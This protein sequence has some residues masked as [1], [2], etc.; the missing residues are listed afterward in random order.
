MSQL[1]IS[2]GAVYDPA[3]GV[4][5]DV[6]D[7][8]IA[9]GRIVASLPDGAPRLDARGMV[10]MPGGIDMHAHIASSSVNQGRRLLPEEHTVDAAPAPALVEG[11]ARSGTG[12]T[13]PSTFTTGYRYAGLG[14][15]TVFDAAVAAAGARDTHAQLDDTPVI[16]AGF[17][18]LMGNDAYLLRQ[19]AAGERDRARDY[20]AWLLGATGAYAIKVVNPGGVEGWKRNVREV[21]S[22]DD[23]APANGVT[24]R[25]ILETL[26]DAAHVLHLPHP[27]HIHCNNLGLPGNVATTLES[28][29]ALTG[30]PAHFTHL[31]FHA[32]A[33]EKGKAWA[34]GATQIAEYVNAHPEVTGDVGQVMF[35]DATTVTADGAVEYLLHASSGRKWVNV[36]VELETGCGIVP[37]AYRDRA[38]IASLQWVVG[39]ELFL[40]STDPWRMALSTDHPNGGTFMSYPELIRLLMDRAYRDERLKGI[41]QKLL[42]GTA[43]ADGLAREYTLGEIAIITRAGP[44]RQLGL[45]RKGHLGVGAD[46]DLTIYSR[47][48]NIAEMFATP[49]YV[50]KDGV[51]VVEEGQLRRA[52]TGRRLH[53]RPGYDDAVTRDLERWFDRYGTVSFANYPVAGVRDTPIQASAISR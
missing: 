39:L 4:D 22:L 21:Q 25:A 40:L 33:G 7:I 26:A 6:R 52:P 36:D 5:G 49:R 23:P 45:V 48:A 34:S 50:L 43:L 24:P 30:R 35:G 18:V 9:D 31:Q 51:L 38:A 28:M 44:A 14:Y 1:R 42:A 29:R 19:I 2:G 8:C 3:N 37:Y 46:A 13:I 10:V 15:T 17:F 20:A 47:N 53:V 11:E 32:Y 27:V 16:D 41:N 12:G